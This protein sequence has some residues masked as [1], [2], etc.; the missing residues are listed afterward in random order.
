MP[1]EDGSLLAL[2]YLE[3]I[4]YEELAAILDVPLGTVKSR[5]HRARQEFKRLMECDRGRV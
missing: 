1:K 2:H 5:L 4:G 3:G